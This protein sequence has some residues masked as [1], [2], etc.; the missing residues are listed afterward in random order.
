MGKGGRDAGGERLS[1]G[2]EGGRF[3]VRQGRNREVR[4]VGLG[5]RRAR[6]KIR[7]WMGAVE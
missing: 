3:G 1:V 4:E 5:R 6:M 7:Q 2:D